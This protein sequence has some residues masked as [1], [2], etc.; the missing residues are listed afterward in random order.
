MGRLV[1]GWVSFYV[2][3]FVGR[4]VCGW[5]GSDSDKSVLNLTYTELD[6]KLLVPKSFASWWLAK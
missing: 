2:G 5:G 4:W 3:G 1:G 6:K